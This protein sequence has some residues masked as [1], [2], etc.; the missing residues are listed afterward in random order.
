MLVEYAVRSNFPNP[1]HFTDDGISCTRF[2]RPSFV[3][4]MEEVE[5]GRVEAVIVK[6]M[7]G[8]HRTGQVPYGY[9]WADE[10][11]EHWV[12]DDDAAVVRQTFSLIMEGSDR[13]RFPNYSHSTASM[14]RWFWFWLPKCSERF[15]HILRVTELSLSAPYRKHR[16]PILPSKRNGLPWQK[17]EPQNLK[18]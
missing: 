9:L 14:P 15:R 5:A 2:D 13:I 12:I 7:S 17:N 1:T 16:P 18:S 4:M 6:G 3:A 10:K 11:R 8:K